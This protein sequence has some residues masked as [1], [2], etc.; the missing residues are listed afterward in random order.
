MLEASFCGVPKSPWQVSISELSN[1][2]S[3]T[4]SRV[5]RARVLVSKSTC[6]LATGSVQRLEALCSWVHGSAVLRLSPKFCFLYYPRRCYLCTIW[7]SQSGLILQHIWAT[8]V[9]WRIRAWLRLELFVVGSFTHLQTLH[10]SKSHK[11]FLHKMSSL[12]FLTQWLYST[13]II[14]PVL[15]IRKLKY[16]EMK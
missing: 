12:T 7:D 8:S 15:S 10:Y 16:K 5:P 3:S 1:H 6:Q 13:M 14:K 4:N 2:T 9:L 11:M